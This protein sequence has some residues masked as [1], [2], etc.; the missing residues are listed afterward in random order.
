MGFSVLVLSCDGNEKEL[1]NNKLY[2]QNLLRNIV[3]FKFVGAVVN[4]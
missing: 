4:M 2:K 1:Y 3:K